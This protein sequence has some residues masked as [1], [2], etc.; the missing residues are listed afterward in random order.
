MKKISILAVAALAM[1][2]C[3]KNVNVDGPAT[4]NDQISFKPA[5]TGMQKGS[6]TSMNNDDNTVVAI[7]GD[8][9]GVFMIADGT[10]VANNVDFEYSGGIFVGGYATAPSLTWADLLNKT[11][12]SVDFHSY[13]PYSST[14]TD[15]T[16]IT[17]T[18]PATQT[19]GVK[20]SD[21]N[22]TTQRTVTANDFI[23]SKNIATDGADKTKGFGQ[24]DV[25]AD[26][27][28]RFNY[29]HALAMVEFNV[30]ASSALPSTEHSW[31]EKIELSG[32]K[33]FSGATIDLSAEEPKATDNGKT[34]TL[35]IAP[36]TTGQSTDKLVSETKKSESTVIYQMLVVPAD[37]DAP[38][39]AKVNLTVKRGTNASYGSGSNSSK[40]YENTFVASNNAS[41]TTKWEAGKRYKYNLIVSENTIRVELVKIDDWDEQP[42]VN[43]P[44][45]PAA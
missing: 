27:T 33:V 18:V 43:L 1:F 21:G 9:F 12:S 7:D 16:S 11:Q 45:P 38:D 35:S 41:A 3:S 25:P 36:R 4:D 31:L 24:T 13:Y 5:I 19:M 37:I 2:S 22:Y 15:H 28:V 14:A 10:A 30:L 17:I 29:A 44:T 6:Y 8:H 42:E 39:D 20:D 23:F 26:R 32:D 34:A 40:K